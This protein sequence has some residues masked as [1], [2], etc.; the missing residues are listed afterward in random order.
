[1]FF[2]FFKIQCDIPIVRAD[3]HD[4]WA[5]AKTIGS[6]LLHELTGRFRGADAAPV[7]PLPG[8]FFRG[9]I[10]TYLPTY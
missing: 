2:Y 9:K 3:M 7:G 5:W 6:F 10:S 8:L 4:A 1:M